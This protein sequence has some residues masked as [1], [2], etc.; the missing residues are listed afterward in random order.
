[1]LRLALILQRHL[2]RMAGLATIPLI[3]GLF[4]IARA[5][6]ADRASNTGAWIT[7]N[8]GP[9]LPS[10][11]IAVANIRAAFPD[12][13]E[14]GIQRIA[15]EAWDNLG[16]TGAEYAHLDTL[17]DFD[18]DG[19][20]R[21]VSVQGIDQFVAVRDDGKP[22]LLFSAH[23]ANWELPAICAAK[24]D[25]ET[26][27]V[28]RPPNNPAAAQF[29]HEVRRKTMGGLAA[30]RPGA[31]FAMQGVI[32]RGGHLGQLIDQH[33]TRGVVVEFFGR[34]VLANPL[35]GKLVRHHECP[36]HGARV[37]RRPGG[38]FTLE[39]TPALD[40]PR[41]ASGQ[42]DVQGAM[43]AMTRVVE[44]WV[45]ENP[46]QWLW[47]HRRWRPNMLPKPKPAAPVAAPAA[48]VE[49]AQAGS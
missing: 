48:A 24:F 13:D 36:V 14:A 17:F 20:E 49:V 18:P 39:L 29:V 27:A 5:L 19:P 3:R 8:V 15:R 30:S 44:G 40:L 2:P 10:H 46:G 35:L 26:T 1:M 34:P 6:G 31:V 42:I 28:F 7:R 12:L 41:D 37:V 11:R 33:F 45:R 43:Q 22:G 47:M 9:W 32:E 4:L 23:L 25:L 21:R 38:R 16:R